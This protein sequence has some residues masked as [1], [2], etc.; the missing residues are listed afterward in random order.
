MY[1]FLL[2]MFGVT[3]KNLHKEDGLPFYDCYS[4]DDTKNGY[5]IPNARQIF[6]ES[7]RI[8]P[9]NWYKMYLTICNTNSE[10]ISLSLLLCLI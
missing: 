5:T 9:W 10:I 4:K 7:L 2:Y 6:L 1:G 8:Y 3:V